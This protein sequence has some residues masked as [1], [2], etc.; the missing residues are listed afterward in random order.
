MWIVAATRYV[1]RGR[2]SPGK[3]PSKNAFDKF[4]ANMKSGEKMGNTLILVWCSE[5]NTEVKAS[6]ITIVNGSVTME[7]ECEHKVKERYMM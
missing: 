5:C 6:K 3:A 1:K 4:K 2:E 7:L